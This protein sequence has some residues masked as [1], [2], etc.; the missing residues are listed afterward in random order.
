MLGVQVRVADLECEVAGMRTVEVQLFERWIAGR[1]REA[2][3]DARPV[4]ESRRLNQHAHRPRERR[5][6]PRGQV[7][8]FRRVARMVEAAAE[9]QRR[10]MEGDFL[11]H[12]RRR[13]LLVDGR[14]ER[15]VAGGRE[16][17]V[18]RPCA[19]AAAETAVGP[20]VAQ[21]LE[22]VRVVPEC[23]P[24]L[25]RNNFFVFVPAAGVRTANRAEEAAE[26]FHFAAHVHDGA[27]R[28]ELDLPLLDVRQAVPRVLVG[29]VRAEV[30]A[31]P[32]PREA[33]R[34]EPAPGLR[35]VDRA[36]WRRVV[37]V[38]LAASRGVQGPDLVA[39]PE[40]RR[41]LCLAAI[42]AQVAREAAL[43]AAHGL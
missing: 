4:V 34:S 1:P 9:L 23:R 41:A 31:V 15:L 24:D 12:E 28:R 2:D 30:A 13:P 25:P 35:I 17:P 11:V 19:D 29:V 26:A 40:V 42:G 37:A 32:G 10:M 36:L 6:V 21:E 16:A 7:V 20:M 18:E 3:R 22:F 5:E 39:P 8:A 38:P 43:H 27:P 33:E 14:R